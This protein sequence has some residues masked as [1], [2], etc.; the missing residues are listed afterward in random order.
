MYVEFRLPSG[1][2]GMA[3]AHAAHIIRKEIG[4]WADKY[5]ISY[6]IKIHKYTLRLCLEADDA[7]THFQISWDPHNPFCSQYSIIHPES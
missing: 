5:C 4:S 2:G 1:A 7:Y 6:K 3:A